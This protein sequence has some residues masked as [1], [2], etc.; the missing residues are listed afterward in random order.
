VTGGVRLMVI[1]V[2]L[3]LFVVPVLAWDW[4]RDQWRYPKTAGV[5]LWVSGGLVGYAIASGPD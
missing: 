3:L 1:G 2:L 4:S 5:M